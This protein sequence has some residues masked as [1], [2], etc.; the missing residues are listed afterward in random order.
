MGINQFR[1]KIFLLLASLSLAILSCKEREEYI[2]YT[3]VSFTVD[4][5]INNELATPG[6]SM[7]YPMEGYGGVI[8]YCEYYDY[9]SPDRSLYHA[10]DAACPYEVNDTCSVVNE[11]NSFYG[12]CPC[13]NS[14]YEFSTGYPVEG[15]SG[16]PLKYYTISV[17][18]NK[19]Y[20]RN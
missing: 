13:C 15:I 3:Y 6:N 4:L 7:I 18:N 19:L 9:L 16:Y 12:V 10:Y 8:I 5:N 20:V 1:I 14:K 11:G 2:P 17:V